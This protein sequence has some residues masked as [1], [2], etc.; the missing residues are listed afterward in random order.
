MKNKMSVKAAVELYAI[1]EIKRIP[2]LKF[3][4]NDMVDQLRS[5]SKFNEYL[6]MFDRKDDKTNETSKTRWIETWERNVREVFKQTDANIKYMLETH[7]IEFGNYV[8]NGKK[9]NSWH[10]NPKLVKSS[11][12]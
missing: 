7:G 6:D 10:Y 11:K 8:L 3:S 4:N 1:C 5:N 9:I 2:F 12:K